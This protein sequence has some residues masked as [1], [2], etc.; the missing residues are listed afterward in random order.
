MNRTAFLK[1]ANRDY[2]RQD[3]PEGIMNEILLG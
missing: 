2:G 3:M 1:P